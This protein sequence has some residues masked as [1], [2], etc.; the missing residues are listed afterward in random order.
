MSALL[1]HL[2]EQ[3]ENVAGEREPHGILHHSSLRVFVCT[4][5]MLKVED[6]IIKALIAGESHIS[7]A[8]DVFLTH[9]RNCFGE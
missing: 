2:L 9:R 3:G 4:E 8:C 6:V 5:M 7:S 1:R